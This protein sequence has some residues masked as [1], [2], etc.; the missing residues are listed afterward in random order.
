MVVCLVT[1]TAFGPLSCGITHCLFL[2]LRTLSGVLE[3]RWTAQFPGA[4]KNPSEW[5]S[6]VDI[7]DAWANKFDH[8]PVKYGQCWV[9]AALQLSFLRAIGLAS[10]YGGA[11]VTKRGHVFPLGTFGACSHGSCCRG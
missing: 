1:P 2:S 7:L 11:K 8:K 9:F 4:Y 10:R 3:G 6:T 5:D